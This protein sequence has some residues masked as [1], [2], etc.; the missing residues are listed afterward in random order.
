M[1]LSALKTPGVYIDEVNAFPPSVAQVS[2]I[3]AF[4]GYTEVDPGSPVKVNSFIEFE[5][6]F[7]GAP[8]PKN[9]II[10]LDDLLNPTDD[11]EVEESIFKLYNSLRLF[12]S[13]GGGVCYVVS[14]GTY[15]KEDGKNRT[16]ALADFKAGLQLLEKLDDPTLI[17][18]PDAVELEIEDLST[19]QQ[20]L[21]AQCGTLKDRFAILDVKEMHHSTK[22]KLDWSLEQFRDKIGTGNLKYGA[23]YYPNLLCNFPYNIRFSDIKWKTVSGGNGLSSVLDASQKEKYDD[24]LLLIGEVDDLQ[25]AFDALSVSSSATITDNATY[26]SESNTML[27]WLKILDDLSGVTH[28]GLK[29][30]LTDS[31]KTVFDNYLDSLILLNQAYNN[32]KESTDA[33]ITADTTGF[34]T[35]LWSIITTP[36][37]ASTNP[38]AGSIKAPIDY[39]LLQK[40]VKGLKTSLIQSYQILFQ[41][42]TGLQQHEENNLIL[43]LPFYN[44]V[45]QYISKSINT[46]PPSGAI[47][48]IYANTDATRG[49]WKAPANVS[50][51]SVLA[52]TDDINDKSQEE[53]NVHVSGKA[54]NAIRKFS[55]KGL[56]VWG[57]RTL[58]AGSLDWRY[59]NV[60]RLAIMIETSAK[61]ASMNFVFE[62]NV[63]QTWVN[64][65][66]MLEN[67]LTTLWN[68]GALAGQKPEHAFF[69]QVGLGQTMTA[70]DIN[71]GRMVVKIGYAPSRPAEFIIL[72]F[73]QVQQRS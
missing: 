2:T 46:L 42:L 31:I 28:T 33:A 64:V 58:D 49:I 54:V 43:K 4:I 57:A 45:L 20:D 72:E 25:D 62:P 8:Q 7:G 47:A 19:L 22:S 12:Y 69:V 40:I 50:L 18:I 67:Y 37:N 63:S 16:P 55:G 26:Q 11:S 9:V 36:Y 66:G 51:K 48:G 73:T 38:Y 53:M 23:A 24:L 71:E 61:H 35:S 56:M 6:I 30:T 5:Q 1:N 52:L 41:K 13:N 68:D 32:F 27:D 34:S 59:I 60:R 44:N 17:V 3:P 29:A 14:A 65:K 21:L 39:S 70:N 15:K 10:I